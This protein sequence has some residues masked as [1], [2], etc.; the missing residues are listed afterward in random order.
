MVPAEPRHIQAADY[1][2]AE[3]VEHHTAPEEEEAHRTLVAEG[4][5]RIP[6]VLTDTRLA[7]GDTGRVLAD[8][9]VAVVVEEDSLPVVVDTGYAM[10][11]RMEAA[12]EGDRLLVPAVDILLE[13]STGLEA[14]TDL[15]VG[16]DPAVVAH[17]PLSIHQQV[18]CER[19]IV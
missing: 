12:G 1:I 5:R 10:A 8:H 18:L 19:A 7:G 9:M 17:I 13:E 15:V 3:A 16:I 6:V 2:L 14:D 4:V 11:H